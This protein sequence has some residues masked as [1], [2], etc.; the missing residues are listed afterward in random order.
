MERRS[1]TE[2]GFFDRL[3]AKE[4]E[5]ASSKYKAYPLFLDRSEY[6]DLFSETENAEWDRSNDE[7]LKNLG[8]AL[9]EIILQNSAEQES[10]IT[11]N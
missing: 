6:F 9:Y 7:M 11:W 4:R 1:L 2:L 3:L 5:M 10:L 8:K